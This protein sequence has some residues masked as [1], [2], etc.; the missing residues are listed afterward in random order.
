MVSQFAARWLF[1]TAH[2]QKSK[3]NRVRRPRRLKC[4]DRCLRGILARETDLT[5]AFLQPTICVTM[6]TSKPRY[7]SQICGRSM[8][9]IVTRSGAALFT[10]LISA[11]ATLALAAPPAIPAA[12]P[13]RYLEDIKALTTP[14]MEG[15]GVWL[16]RIDAGRTPDREAIQK[17]W[18]RARWHK[19]YLQPFTRDHR[20]ATKREE[21]FR[22]V[23]RRQQAGVEG[24]A[25]LRS[26]QLFR[27][28]IG[29]RDVIF[30]GYGVT[31]DE[32][33]YDDYAGPR[34]QRQNCRRDALRASFV[35][36]EG[37]AIKA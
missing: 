17:P 26:L 35:C 28:R 34:R 22:G 25:G 2:F 23:G 1:N 20:R 8:Q 24:E 29:A 16:Q 31:A 14:A 4:A 13:H 19:S 21:R 32:F 27:L 12:D 9:N 11:F 37:A 33:Q 36:G 30:A 10:L 5:Q 7:C 15:R 3:N 18:P 6:P